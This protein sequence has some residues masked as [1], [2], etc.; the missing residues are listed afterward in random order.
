G[1]GEANDVISV[2]HTFSGTEASGNTYSGSGIHVRSL[3][4]GVNAQ[5]TVHGI[6]SNVKIANCLFSYSICEETALFLDTASEVAGTNLW[7][8]DQNVM[9]PV[10]G[11][12]G[13]ILGS[14][15]LVNSY[16]SSPI[17]DGGWGEVITTRPSAGGGDDSI[18][19][20]TQATYPLDAG[21]AIVGFASGASAGW[22]TGIQIGGAAGG[23]M[24]PGDHSIIG[25]GIKLLDTLTTGI[26]FSGAT[27]SG[28]AI[29]FAP[30][31]TL[32]DGT[33][34][35]TLAQ[36]ASGS[37]SVA[38]SS[39]T[40]TGYFANW[41]TA[42]GLSLTSNLYQAS[43]TGYIG[44]GTTNPSTTLQIA[45]ASSTI[46]I[47]A[48]AIPGCLELMDSTGNSVINYITA[49]GGTLT[50]TTTQPANCE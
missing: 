14:S 46:R 6:S 37:G 4:S 40:S 47:G 22:N 33:V 30:S 28:S 41:V 21:L 48:G 45:G 29:K 5:G 50:A 7:G 1:Q 16:N 3:L 23:W 26:D 17:S 32:T 31:Q 25:T 18:I 44:I 24:T 13:L 36:L 49:S 35:K 27:F 38:T 9:G 8:T 12:A 43:S 39:A 2:Q 20:S 42:N 10:T 11:Q 34:I 15:I 19:R